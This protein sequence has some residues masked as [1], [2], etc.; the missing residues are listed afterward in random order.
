MNVLLIGG[1]GREHALAWKLRQSTELETLY[2]A[3]G[4]PGILSIAEL[5][6][7][8]I[9]NHREV[10]AVC[11]A[12]NIGLVVIGPEAPLVAGLADDLR[13]EGITVFGSSAAAAR[14]EASKSFT[15]AICDARG[16]PTA[17]YGHFANRERALAYARTQGA[18]LVIKADGLASGKGVM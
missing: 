1:G 9:E 17:T 3:P 13:S 16:I 15:K 4:N 7:V 8:H 2:C 14:L 18:P 5:A 12:A 6:P 11:R 10:G